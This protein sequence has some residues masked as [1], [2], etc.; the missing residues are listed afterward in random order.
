MN[1]NSSEIHSESLKQ[2]ATHFAGWRKMR[3]MKRICQKSPALSFCKSGESWMKTFFL[4]V[5]SILNQ[6][7]V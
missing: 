2:V 7:P 1:T 3:A 6:S 5:Y 4:P